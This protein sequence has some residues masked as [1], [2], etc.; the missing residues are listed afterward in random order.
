MKIGA[1]FLLFSGKG[2][3][4]T[5]AVKGAFALPGYKIPIYLILVHIHHTVILVVFFIVVV[6][7]AGF[8]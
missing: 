6:V 8:T 4:I 7:P 5:L 3:I 1:A 2:I